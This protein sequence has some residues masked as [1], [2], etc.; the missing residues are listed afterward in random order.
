MTS[1]LGK[2]LGKLR[3]GKL[4][5]NFGKPDFKKSNSLSGL[6]GLPIINSLWFTTTPCRGSKPV[7]LVMLYGG[8]IE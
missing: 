7:N 8:M 6:H 3:V 5:V 4:L 2:L 1:L